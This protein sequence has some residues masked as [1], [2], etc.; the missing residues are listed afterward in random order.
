MK[1][2]LTMEDQTK[3]FVE[4]IGF[5]SIQSWNKF[6]EE[7]PEEAVM[8]GAHFNIGIKAAIDKS[9]GVLVW[10]KVD[11]KKYNN[12]KRSISPIRLSRAVIKQPKLD[13]FEWQTVL[14]DQ[15][16]EI[17]YDPRTKSS[18]TSTVSTT[19]DATTQT[20]YPV[21]LHLKEKREMEDLIKVLKCSISGHQNQTAIYQFENMEMS[22]K[23]RLINNKLQDLYGSFGVILRDMCQHVT[24]PKKK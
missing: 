12:L 10:R 15:V 23:I 4:L 17:P 11:M 20:D 7:N 21:D 18:P 3:T 8:I 6:R 9:K 19:Y 24:I 16:P 14:D 22:R 5:T 1:T 2:T 13:N